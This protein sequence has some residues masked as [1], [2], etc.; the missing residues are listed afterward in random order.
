MQSKN[1]FVKS[2]PLIIFILIVAIS[3]GNVPSDEKSHK[4]HNLLLGTW[5]STYNETFIYD[6]LTFTYAYNSSINYKMEAEKIIWGSDT[7]GIIYGRYTTNTYSPQVVGLYYA[8]SFKDLS[9]SQVSISGAYKND[10][11]KGTDTLQ[12]AID[13]F[14][15]DKGY[16][17]TYSSCTKSK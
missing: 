11:K 4:N 17:S 8:V 12:E 6:G 1:N 13:E 14:T 3:C 9:D 5:T 15:E 16:Y 10:E 2:L 7:S